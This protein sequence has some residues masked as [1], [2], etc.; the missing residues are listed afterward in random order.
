[1]K[2]LVFGILAC[3]VF[4]ITSGMGWFNA[5]VG[6]HAFRYDARVIHEWSLTVTVG[7]AL[8][9]T[10][11]FLGWDRRRAIFPLMLLTAPLSAFLHWISY[12][13]PDEVIPRFIEVCEVIQN[14]I[15]D[16]TA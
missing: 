12:C 16:L 15:I 3:A 7:G 6:E 11:L 10:V 8:C 13:S 1:M 9:I 14:V 2:K 5:A 4:G